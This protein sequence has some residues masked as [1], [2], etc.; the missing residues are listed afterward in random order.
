MC[1]PRSDILSPV[2]RIMSR[3]LYNVGNVFYGI[4]GRRLFLASRNVH[5]I[6]T[7]HIHICLSRSNGMAPCGHP[8][9]HS[10]TCGHRNW[11][12]KERRG[13][14]NY[15]YYYLQEMNLGHFSF[16]CPP[17]GTGQDSV[18]WC[19]CFCPVVLFQWIRYSNLCFLPVLPFWS[20]FF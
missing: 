7:S 16:V 14:G 20:Q 2:I 9:I 4:T 18:Q 17:K 11:P 10:F 5:G 12:N 19:S 6:H 13:H 3:Q 1:Q 8:F 15:Y